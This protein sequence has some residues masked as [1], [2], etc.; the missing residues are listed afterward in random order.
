M[1]MDDCIEFFGIGH[2]LCYGQIIGKYVILGLNHSFG[3]TEGAMAAAG[4]VSYS[5]SKGG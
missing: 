3:G 5:S 2:V 1:D 4:L